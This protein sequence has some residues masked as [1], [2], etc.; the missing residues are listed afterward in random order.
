MI[1]KNKNNIKYFLK[2]NKSCK[3][4]KKYH[5]KFKQKIK[6]Y[7]KIVKFC[8]FAGRQ[9]NMCILHSYIKLLLSKHI[10]DEYHIFDFSRNLIDKQFLFD[11]YQ[12]LSISFPN[13]IFLH[14]YKENNFKQKKTHQYDWSPFYSTISK[15]TFY[16][17]S[18]IIK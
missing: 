9:K 6:K 4:F 2:W 16:D 12:N 1:L 17:N 13:K 5:K 14:N 10:I 7:N 11:S 8:V 3:I 15:K 18:I